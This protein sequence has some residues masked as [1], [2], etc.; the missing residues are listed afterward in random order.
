MVQKQLEI[1]KYSNTFGRMTT[2]YA[3]C[4]REIKSGIATVKAAFNRK[5]IL[6]LP[7]NWT[8]I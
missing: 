8:Y 6:V 2:D 7:A 3:R 1:L 4:I 5:R